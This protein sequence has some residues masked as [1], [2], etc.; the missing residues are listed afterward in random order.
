MPNEEFYSFDESM[1][2]YYGRHGCKQFLRGKPIRFGF[3]IWCGTTPLGYLVW[4]DPYQG[5][6]DSSRTQGKSFGLGGNLVTK[7]ADVLASLGRKFF[8]LCYDNVF[9]SVKLVT[10]LKA[11]FVKATGTI[12]ENRTEK[13]PRISN[14]ALKKQGR[15]NYDFKTD[16]NHG[17]IVCKW[18]DNSVVNLCS[19][20]AGVHPI[21]NASRYSS[22]EKKRVQIEQPYLVKLYNENMGGVD[23]MDQ[24]ISNYR[25]AMRGKSGIF[26]WF[27]IC[28]I[29]PSTMHGDCK[30]IV[31]KIRWIY[32]TF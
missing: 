24:N 10:T 4:I 28:L 2:K 27:P 21:S 16:T 22:S 6:V 17:V 31:M 25:I 20:A 9:N 5:K 11:K 12:R 7:F 32:Y 1:C 18:N 8:H 29:F 3:K 13:C 30:K 26:A 14:D 15:G 19:N 23:R